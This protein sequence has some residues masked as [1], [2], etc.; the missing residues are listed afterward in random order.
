M[1]G[2]FG[3]FVP[4]NLGKTGIKQMTS[5][6]EFHIAAL[7]K[8]DEVS[9]FVPPFARSRIPFPQRSVELVNASRDVH[10]SGDRKLQFHRNYE[11]TRES[12]LNAFG[13]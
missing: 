9:T 10:D 3:P 5:V 13:R 2:E 8:S 7:V 6:H 12:S 1:I 11:K 4:I